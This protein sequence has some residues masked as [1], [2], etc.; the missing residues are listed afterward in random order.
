MIVRIRLPGTDTA[1]TLADLAAWLGREDELRGQVAVEQQPVS[2]GDMGTWPD[3]LIVALGS[4]GAGTALAT[5]L[6]LWIRYRKPRVDIEITR[7][8]G[9]SVKIAAQGLPENEVARVLRTALGE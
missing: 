2:T 3:V 7:D 6:G 4:G 5:S 9:D 8:N 1:A